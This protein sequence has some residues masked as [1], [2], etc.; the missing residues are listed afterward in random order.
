LRRR[1]TASAPASRAPA[2]DSEAS[3]AV[4]QCPISREEPHATPARLPAVIA[5]ARPSRGA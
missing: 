5:K 4:S 3:E 2:L 1:A